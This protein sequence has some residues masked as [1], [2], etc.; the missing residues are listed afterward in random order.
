MSYILDAL[1]KNKSGEDNNEVPDLSSEHAYHELEEEKSFRQWIWPIIVIVL[2][3]TI[4]VL[5]F[6]LLNPSAQHISE[7]LAQRQTAPAVVANPPVT[8]TKDE[9]EE[10]YKTVEGSDDTQVVSKPL[11]VAEP[12][13]RKVRKTAMPNR[14]SQESTVTQAPERNTTASLTKT[15][16]PRLVYTTHIYATQAKDRFVM[17]NGKAYAQGDKISAELEIKEIL[18][19]D[20]VVVF[21]GQEFVLPS[22]EDVN[23][24]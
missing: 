15:D 10:S 12:V 2:I 23:V 4:G 5:I 1:K 22:L 17:L 16:L 13:V 18:E 14:T 21:K 3:L 8:Q 20:L 7:Q 11:Q 6:I 19:N 24:E 9:V